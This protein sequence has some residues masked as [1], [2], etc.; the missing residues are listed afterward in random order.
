MPRISR[1]LKAVNV[2]ASTPFAPNMRSIQGVLAFRVCGAPKPRH[3]GTAVL[4]VGRHRVAGCGR[5]TADPAIR[6]AASREH[7]RFQAANHGQSRVAV[8]SHGA[9]S[10][11]TPRRLENTVALI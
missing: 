10:T 3:L 7:E 1:K 6:A 5:S 8:R 2:W 9:A 11:R 4:L